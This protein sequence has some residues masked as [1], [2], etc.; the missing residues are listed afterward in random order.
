[1]RFEF[2]SV[3]MA[4]VVFWVIMLCGLVG[5]RALTMEAVSPKLWYFGTHGVIIENA[6][7]RLSNSHNMFVLNSNEKTQ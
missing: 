5:V 7:N 3:M 1:M 2:P 6:I 4:V